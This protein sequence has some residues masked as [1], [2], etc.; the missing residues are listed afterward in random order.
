MAPDGTGKQQRFLKSYT[1]MHPQLKGHDVVTVGIFDASMIF[2]F[3]NARCQLK[4]T[5]HLS[6]TVMAG[7]S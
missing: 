4:V 3:E 7:A 1:I 2:D 5:I 6:L